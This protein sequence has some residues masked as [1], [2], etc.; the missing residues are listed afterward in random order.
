ML[1]QEGVTEWQRVRAGLGTHVQA[2]GE[3]IQPDILRPTIRYLWQ[4]A[5]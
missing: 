2:L 5:F 3:A 4:Q 1:A